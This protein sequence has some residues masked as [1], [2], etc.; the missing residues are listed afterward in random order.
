VAAVNQT[1]LEVETLQRSPTFIVIAGVQFLH[2][3]ARQSGR[4]RQTVESGEG[5]S[6]RCADTTC[7]GSSVRRWLSL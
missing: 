5:G 7:R 6:I 3:A 2:F 1:W 4:V